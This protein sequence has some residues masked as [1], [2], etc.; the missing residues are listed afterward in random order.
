MMMEVEDNDQCDGRSN[1]EFNNTQTQVLSLHFFSSI[2]FCSRTNFIS[3][4]ID[5]HLILGRLKWPIQECEREG[6][7]EVKE[8]KCDNKLVIMM[9]AVA[10]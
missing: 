4:N 5:D 6:E 3:G 1:L 8:K 9:M 10:R 7:N 2:F